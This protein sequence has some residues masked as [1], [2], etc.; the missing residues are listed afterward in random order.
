MRVQ[1]AYECG[2]GVGATRRGV[3][4]RCPPPLPAKDVKEQGGSRREGA[5]ESP[6]LR[7]ATKAVTHRR[8]SD[9]TRCAHTWLGFGLGLGM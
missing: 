3:P 8:S 6:R 2:V 7:P 9:S 5:G 1:S 4:T